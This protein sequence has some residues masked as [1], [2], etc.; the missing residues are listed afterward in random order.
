MCITFLRPYQLKAVII[1][2]K[3]VLLIAIYT[4]HFYKFRDITFK[5]VHV[6]CDIYKTYLKF[7]PSSVFIS[8]GMSSIG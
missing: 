2:L 1:M 6:R 5:S 4:G 8:S 7:H 3:I